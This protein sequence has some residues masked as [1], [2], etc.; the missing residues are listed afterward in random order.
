MHYASLHF[1][2]QMCFAKT[3]NLKSSISRG[4]DII[5]TA[6]DTIQFN[7]QKTI[8][9]FFNNVI[10]LVI[11]MTLLLWLPNNLNYTKDTILEKL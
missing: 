7:L 1:A 8:N 2:A 9:T 3:N 4:W 5:V 10:S 6:N 11:P